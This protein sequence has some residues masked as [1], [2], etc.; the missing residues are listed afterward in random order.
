MNGKWL[1]KDELD[2]VQWIEADIKVV[3]YLKEN[4]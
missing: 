2:S 1:S 4:L 3:N